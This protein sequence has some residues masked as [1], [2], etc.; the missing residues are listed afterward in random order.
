[1]SQLVPHLEGDQVAGGE[2]A[3]QG[4][5]VVV[6]KVYS[7]DPLR[8]D[9]EAHREQDMQRFLT[10]ISGDIRA[11][12]LR[13]GLRLAEIERLAE[14][15]GDKHQDIAQ[16]ALELYVPLADPMGMGALRTRLEDVCFRILQPAVFEELALH[17]SQWKEKTANSLSS[18][19][20]TM[21]R[22]EREGSTEAWELG[23]MGAHFP[24]PKV[25]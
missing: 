18:A 14:Q 4:C 19:F 25:V 10:S 23:G 5:A 11:V 17:V 22:L 2:L 6:E 24:P 9:T 13:I 7:E 15:G 21:R 16:E 1:V 20:L 3:L 8:T 12:I